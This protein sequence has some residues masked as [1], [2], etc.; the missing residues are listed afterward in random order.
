MKPFTLSM[1]FL[2]LY[3]LPINAQTPTDTAL[4]A[5]TSVGKE[6]NGNKAAGEAVKAIVAVGADALE[7]TLKAFANANPAA[8]NWLRMTAAQIV[9][10][11]AAS[12]KTDSLIAFI[13]DT[14]N[15]TGARTAAFDIVAK[16]KPDSAAALKQNFLNDPSIDLR[17]MTIDELLK[18]TLDDKELESVFKNVRD[19]DQAEK[20]A[21]MLEE[22][23]LPADLT[24][25][26]G[27]LTNWQIV[28]PFDSTAG[29]GFAKSFP[30]ESQFDA[31]ATFEGKSGKAMK[32][33]TTSTVAKYGIVDLNSDIGKHMDAVAYATSTFTI[34]KETPCE[35]RVGSKNA[36]IIFLNGEK[37]FERE[38]YHHGYSMDQHNAVGKLKAG[39]NRVVLKIV[40]NNQKESWA[41]EW[42]FNLRICDSTGGKLP[43]TNTIR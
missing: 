19:K 18:K 13:N 5:I 31:A 39:E 35:I 20:I 28:G 8:K 42:A 37:L 41:Q 11:H 6:G 25:H 17:R 43:I 3:S 9:D 40:Q 23:K 1:L 36:V 21:K 10:Q 16:L 29:A 24:S 12:I 15:D 26:F 34:D 38:T 32:W 22:R 33:K 27:F 2:A 14:T 4:K 7:P 30:P